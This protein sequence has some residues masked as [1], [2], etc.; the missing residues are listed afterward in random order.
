MGCGFFDEFMIE[1]LD[2]LNGIFAREFKV[3]LVG[4]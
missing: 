1:F 4:N 2:L 3:P